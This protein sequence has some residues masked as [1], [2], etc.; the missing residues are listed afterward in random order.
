MLATLEKKK[1]THVMG[2][3]STRLY[4]IIND[5]FPS[6]FGK[7]FLSLYGSVIKDYLGKGVHEPG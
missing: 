1:E 5:L 4:G 7:I 2:G 3:W 6:L